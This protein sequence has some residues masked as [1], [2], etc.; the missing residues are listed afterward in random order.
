MKLINQTIKN[1]KTGNCGK[2]IFRKIQTI[3]KRNPNL[4]L[5]KKLQIF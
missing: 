1:L 5:Y 3:L 2:K 4:M